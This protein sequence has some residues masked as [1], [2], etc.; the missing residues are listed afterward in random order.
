M[1]EHAL[2][3]TGW[4]F[5][6]RFRL[7][8][9]GPEM[10]SGEDMIAQALSILLNT[11]IGERL[12]HQGF[13]CGLQQFMFHSLDAESLTDIKEEI[14]KAILHHEPRVILKAI[15]FDTENIYDGLLQIALSYV[16]KQTNSP[17]NM[18]FPFYLSEG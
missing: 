16:I 7:P 18:V 14:A 11:Q 3:G 1:S 9:E 10:C 8:K 5:P 4:Q 6:V 15:Q 13:G 2:I 12:F 17:G